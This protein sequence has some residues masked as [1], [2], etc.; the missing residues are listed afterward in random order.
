MLSYNTHH[1]S[2]SRYCQIQMPSYIMHHTPVSTQQTMSDVNAL[3]Q[4]THIHNTTYTRYCQIQMPSYTIHHTPYNTQHT[5]SDVDAL[6]HHTPT[7]HISYT[8]TPY[9]IHLHTIQYT[10][11]I[12]RYRCPHTPYTI[13]HTTH[14]RQ[15][16]M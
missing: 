3:I 2:Y 12:V 11:D 15:C 8:R 13:H 4:H 9:N 1:T 16:R 5:A 6:I 7:H 14:N 10:P